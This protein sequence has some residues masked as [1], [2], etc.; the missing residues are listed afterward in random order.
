MAK[1]ENEAEQPTL[2]KGLKLTMRVNGNSQKVKSIDKELSRK[3]KEE[4]IRWQ[5]NGEKNRR[6]A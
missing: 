6:I 4:R 5:L 3:A 2:E 1:E